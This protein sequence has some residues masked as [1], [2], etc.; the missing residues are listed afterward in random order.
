MNIYKTYQKELHENVIKYLEERGIKVLDMGIYSVFDEGTSYT[1]LP[2]YIDIQ[3]EPT[4]FKLI[5]VTDSPLSKLT[6]NTLLTR[7]QT[8]DWTRPYRELEGTYCIHEGSVKSYY[9]VKPNIYIFKWNVC[10][11][12]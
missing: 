5:L 9:N 2:L 11:C 10:Y 1:H 6:Q 3:G 4:E 8:G 12:H 7:L